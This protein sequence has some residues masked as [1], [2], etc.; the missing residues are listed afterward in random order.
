MPK[1]LSLDIAFERAKAV[2]AMAAA[3]RLIE[4]LHPVPDSERSK[5][6]VSARLDPGLVELAKRRS[7]LQ[8]DTEVLTAAL[9]HYVTHDSYGEWLLSQ[10]GTISEDFE[11]DL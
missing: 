5:K 10:K 11:L 7:G 6:R 8:S 9:A 2:E 4:T 3:E 1:T